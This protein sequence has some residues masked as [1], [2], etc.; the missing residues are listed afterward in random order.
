MNLSLQEKADLF[1]GVVTARQLVNGAVP[2]FCQELVETESAQARLRQWAASGGM[3]RTFPPA[4]IREELRYY[5][6]PRML[7]A[8]IDAVASVPPPVRDFVL[9][10]VALLGIGWVHIGRTFLAPFEGQRMI[11]LSG[12]SHDETRIGRLVL[13]ELAHAWLESPALGE[14]ATCLPAAGLENVDALARDE[15]WLDDA[16]RWRRAKENRAD[17][18]AR[19]WEASQ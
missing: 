5:G 11:I 19:Q 18:L 9:E 16:F 8:V 3:A 12:A 15:G 13:H 6:D 17:A 10:E 1:G 4:R 14:V 7:P 2:W